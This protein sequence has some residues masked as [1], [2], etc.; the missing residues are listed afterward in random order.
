MWEADP[1]TRV[2]TFSAE[3]S[4]HKALQYKAVNQ[5]SPP[6][7]SE[8][9]KLALNSL[10]VPFCKLGL[11]TVTSPRALFSHILLQRA[12]LGHGAVVEKEVTPQQHSSLGK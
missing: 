1:G 12:G 5:S 6:Q 10:E 8:Y 3:E 11:I 9:P 2:A 7:F 4:K